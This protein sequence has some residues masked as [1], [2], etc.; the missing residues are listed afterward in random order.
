MSVKPEAPSGVG[1]QRGQT[2][3]VRVDWTQKLFVR[4]SGGDDEM[5]AG[6][7]TVSLRA[8]LGKGTQQ[9]VDSVRSSGVARL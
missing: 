9:R 1:G 7:F 5:D 4:Y 3:E 8:I 6:E 2:S